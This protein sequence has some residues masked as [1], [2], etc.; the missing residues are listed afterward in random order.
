MRP[1]TATAAI[2]IKIKG[3]C[4]ILMSLS[5]FIFETSTLAFQQIQ[6]QRS[7][8]FADNAVASG[9]VKKQFIG[10]GA[11][12]VTLPG[13]IYEEHGFGQRSSLDELAAMA[14]TG[15]GFVL[16][17]GSGYL[18]GVYIIDSLDETK[19]ILTFDGVPR[20]IDF[21]LKLSR[22]DDKRIEQQ[23]VSNHRA[24]S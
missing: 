5:Q 17:D 16:M 9:R 19:Q 6:R 10:V 11:D 24:T 18:Y 4:M 21:T 23:T 22:V 8:E 12:V 20:K 7:W 15:Q 14:D 2:K 1:V 3:I 13:L